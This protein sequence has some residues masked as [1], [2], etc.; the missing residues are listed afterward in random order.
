MTIEQQLDFLFEGSYFAD[1]A[2]LRQGQD[3]GESGIRA[4]MRGEMK[5]KLERSAK[6]GEPLRIYIGADPTRTSLHIGHMVPV[7]KLRRF[8]TLGHQVIFLIGDYTAMIGDPTGQSSERKRLTHDDVME[9]AKFYTGQAHRLLDPDNTEIRFNGEWLGRLSFAETTEIAAQFPLS[10]IIARQDFRDRLDSGAGVRLHECFYSLMQ[11]YDA[12]ALNC[13]VQVGGYDQHFNLLA[14]RILQKYFAERHHPDSG[15]ILAGQPHPLAAEQ[16]QTGTAVKGPHVMLTFPLLMGTDGRKMSKSWGNTIDVLEKPEDM[17]GKVMRITD[18]MI[19]HYI[20]IALEGPKDLKDEWKA[21][22]DSEPM[23]VKK[24]V[25][26]RIT[27]MYNGEEAAEEAAAHFQRTVQEKSF[28]E[29]DIPEV[30][31][32]AEMKADAKL[33][34]LIVHLDAAPS[35]KEAQRLIESG[36]VKL[37]DEAVTDKMATYEH[38]P[39]VVLKVGKRKVFKLV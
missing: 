33:A 16:P 5:K 20:D 23:E 22:I 30:A 24:W 27:A 3:S 15:D 11:G 34:D 6:T 7:V 29:E 17:F 13:D 28:A 9:M 38:K 37:D 4:Q 10:Q 18:E 26:T 12:F 36:A 39:G 14:G 1:E 19:A 8:Q 25:A 21:R 2:S 32:P 35:K 31:V